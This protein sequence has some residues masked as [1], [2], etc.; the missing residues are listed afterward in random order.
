MLKSLYI[1]NYALISELR[2]SFDNGLTVI[3]GETGAGKSIIIGALSLILGQRADNKAIREG[4]DKCII[5][6]GFNISGYS[7][8]NFFIGNELDYFQECIIRRELTVTGKSR[9]FINDTPVSL[10]TIRE[11]SLKLIDIHS[12]HENLLLSNDL[13]QLKVVDTVAK[14]QEILHRYQ[15]IFTE[16]KSLENELLSLKRLAEKQSG[17]LD[18]IRFQWQQLADAKLQEGEQEEL[19]AEQRILSHAGEIKSE[20]QKSVNLLSEEQM[21]L[22]LLKE[23][24]QS[25]GH[26]RSFLDDNNDWYDRLNSIHIDLKDIESDVSAY[27]ERLEF[28]PERLESIE[29]RLSEIYSLQKKFKVGSI[30]GLIETGN[31]L[32]K[33]LNRIESFDEELFRLQKN[34]SEKKLELDGSSNELTSSRTAVC[35]VIESYMTTQLAE[36]GIPNIRFKVDISPKSEYSDMGNDN[37]LFMFSANKN[38]EL[39]P[40]AQVASGGEISRVML[41]IKSL[42]AHRSDLPSIIFDEVDTGVSGEIAFKMGL[43]M[44]EMASDM[45]VISITHLPQIAAKGDHHFRVYKDDLGMHT[46]TRIMKLDSD[47]RILELAKMLSA[48]KITDAAVAQAKELLNS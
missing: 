20:L 2:L 27:N 5:E 16:W 28:D 13:Y 33:Q 22:P 10:N 24:M 21:V 34:I 42:I 11:L 17:D 36:L 48:N 43:I 44:K 30:A 8:E 9:A 23:V 47:E 31:H 6:A 15:Q 37:V 1:S 38:R 3:T 19:E 45:Q 39:L 40:V 4:A 29:A 18:Y 14:N 12:Q 7:L 35:N 25:V 41:A 46:E 32:E 26:I